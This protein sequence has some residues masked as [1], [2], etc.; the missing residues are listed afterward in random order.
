MNPRISFSLWKLSVGVYSNLKRKITALLPRPVGRPSQKPVVQKF[1][2]SGGE[3]DDG[4][5][6]GGEGGVPLRLIVPPRGVHREQRSR[7]SNPAH[8]RMSCPG[9]DRQTGR[10]LM[11]SSG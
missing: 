9:R 4:P 7:G 1:S 11:L 5:A 6:G 10:D 2:L 8:L 3:L